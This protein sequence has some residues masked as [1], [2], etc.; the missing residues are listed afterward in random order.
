MLSDSDSSFDDS[1]SSFDD[2]FNPAEND[3][4]LC[5]EEDDPLLYE[6][7]QAIMNLLLQVE[8]HP[9]SCPSCQTNDILYRSPNNGLLHNMFVC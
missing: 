6:L 2:D 3:C 5:V 8:Q 7:A 1:D 9:G 4:V